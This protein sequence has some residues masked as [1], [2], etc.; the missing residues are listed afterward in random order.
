MKMTQHGYETGLG[1]LLYYVFSA[2]QL[3]CA[4]VIIMIL[5][6]APYDSG[7]E[8]LGAAL[9]AVVFIVITIAKIAVMAA[10]GATSV[11]FEKYVGEDE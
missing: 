6:N 7:S 5:V 10:I 4:G 1:K 9:F 3:G 2:L 8:M 11:A